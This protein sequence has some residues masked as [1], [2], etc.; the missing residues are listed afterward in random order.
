MY[1]QILMTITLKV[2]NQ[3]FF[4]SKMDAIDVHK[5]VTSSYFLFVLVFLEFKT[6]YTNSLRK[7]D[8]EK[9]KQVIKQDYQTAMRLVDY[10]NYVKFLSCDHII[11]KFP[12]RKMQVT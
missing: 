12:I 8:Y 5:W 2:N 3:N 7:I 9:I 11:L 4:G 6:Q 10:R 1:L